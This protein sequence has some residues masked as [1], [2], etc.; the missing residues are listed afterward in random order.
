MNI[1]ITGKPRSGKTRLLE[2]IINT[3]S[4]NLIGFISR[5]V[6]KD[7]ERIGFDIVT[8]AGE[9]MPLARVG[10]ESEYRVSRYGI[11]IS[12][13]ERAIRLLPR[14]SPEDVLYIDE[15]GKM[16]LYSEDFKGLIR[17]Y[18]DSANTFIFTL[19]KVFSDET[20]R[21]IKARDDV[22]ILDLDE[23]SPEDVLKRIEPSIRQRQ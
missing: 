14:H 10:L 13:L 19:T 17:K 3:R 11:D 20:I 5:E 23:L 15:V 12:S 1:G 8:N 9:V 2:R 22:R 7:G 6:V 4:G 21:S 18:L 16:E